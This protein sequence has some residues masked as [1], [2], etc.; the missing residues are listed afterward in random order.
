VNTTARISSAW[1]RDYIREH[2]AV[3]TVTSGLVVE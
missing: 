1:L 3:M 2:G